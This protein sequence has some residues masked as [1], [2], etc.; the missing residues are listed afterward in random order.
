M[1]AD[2]RRVWAPGHDLMTTDSYVG[3]LPC[4]HI[5]IKGP[6]SGL[7]PGSVAHFFLFL[8]QIWDTI[9]IWKKIGEELGSVET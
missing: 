7:W 6:E 5:Y 2:T 1:V 3:R 4:G 9:E 8:L